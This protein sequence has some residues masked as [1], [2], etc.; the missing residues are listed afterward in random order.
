MGIVTLSMERAGDD[1]AIGAMCGSSCTG[2]NFEMI[3]RLA[4]TNRS[5]LKSRARSDRTV[6]NSACNFELARTAL[7]FSTAS[8][9]LVKSREEA[10]MTSV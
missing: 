2:E 8:W 3:A 7:I 1:V 9:T 5:A 6:R 4:V 10:P